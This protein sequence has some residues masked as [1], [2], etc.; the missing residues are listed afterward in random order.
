MLY[1]AF[2]NVPISFWVIENDSIIDCNLNA[3]NLFGY[4]S[5]DDL[6]GLKPFDLSPYS[7]DDGSESY[8]KGLEYIKQAQLNKHVNFMWRHSKK[9]GDT[10]LAYINL[11]AIK[12]VLFAIITNIDEI[13]HYEETIKEK[14]EMYKLLF[15]QNKNM[16]LFIDA[17]TL[18]ITDANEAAINFY[19]YD[20]NTLRKKKYTDIVVNT[21]E[22]L[23]NIDLV[24]T[25]MQNTFY[26][27]HKLANNEI[28]DVE[29][30][31]FSIALNSKDYLINMIYDT[32]EKIKQ[33]IIIN[34]FLHQSPYPI[35]VLDNNQ[36]VI[37]INDKFTELFQYT[38]EEVLGNNLNDLL[39]PLELRNELDDNIDKV[40]TENFIRVTTI[41][42]RKDE[43]LI[44]VEILAFPITYNDKIIGAYVHYID[45]T[46]KIKDQNQLQLFKK[47][48]ENNNEGIIITNS[49]EEIEWVNHAFTKIS[50]YTLEDLVGKTPSILRSDVHT[51]EFYLKMWDEIREN[52]HW[53][54]EIWN[55]DKHGEIYPEW[56]NIYAIQNNNSITNYVG[57][58]KDLS[59][60]KKIDRKMR[61]LAQK[62]VLTGLYNRV[63]LTDIIS[64]TICQNKDQPLAVLFIDLN[65]FKEINDTLGHH[66]GDTFLIEIAQRFQKT[67]SED[68]NIARYGGDE[69]VFLVPGFSSKQQITKI[70]R[71]ILNIISQPYRVD[72]H[73]LYV[74]ASLGISLYPKDGTTCDELFQ[75]A[76]IAMYVAKSNLE[77]KI[78]YYTPSMRKKIDERFKMAV[79]MREAIEKKAYTLYFEPLYDLKSNKIISCEVNVDWH[80]P[81]L[82]AYSK[83]KYLDIA[84]QTGQI[85]QIFAYTFEDICRKLE[86]EKDFNIPISI[87]I[88][89]EQLEQTL[90]INQIKDIIKRYNFNHSLIVFEFTDKSLANYS[91]RVKKTIH[92]LLKL[93]FSFTLDEFGDDNSSI[94][95]LKHYYIKSIKLSP[96][97]LYTIDEKNINYELI[98]LYRIIS[99][100]MNIKLFATGVKKEQQDAIIRE[101]AFDGAQGSYYAK[102]ITFEKLKDLS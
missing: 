94:K 15:E 11:V 59:E 17:K 20:L 54:G 99:Q 10:F 4:N 56:L 1:E 28:R 36:L 48:L 38:K 2:D 24:L 45:I 37:N 77:N 75:N 92:N 85:N 29:V 3:V 25:N 66:A 8:E 58:I 44:D 74:T 72:G 98:K 81:E 23:N 68:I 87:N 78:V 39:T 86:Q 82:K 27:K 35:A 102:A 101:L 43:S 47:V 97:L 79:L 60:S 41:R 49:K 16:I 88:A 95:Q 9:N 22:S 61:V 71:K 21:K 50:G 100:E 13:K 31:I 93:G 83:Q 62:D 5:K 55:K 67:F 30:N 91:T 90:F 34:T 70:A 12:D 33:N 69:F 57:I 73:F 65:H 51:P 84:C 64:K 96:N 7:Q 63:H 40:F 52:K 89:I 26:T 19:G 14:D 80:N 32:T 76:D 53:S 46:Q 6:I 42:K 18:Q